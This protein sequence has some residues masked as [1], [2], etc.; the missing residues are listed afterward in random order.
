MAHWTQKLNELEKEY[1]I[2]LLE[3]NSYYELMRKEYTMATTEQK[4]ELVDRILVAYNGFYEAYF[5]IYAI[6]DSIEDFMS[7]KKC[8]IIEAIDSEDFIIKEF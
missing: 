8:S 2:M 5:S 7:A 1:V 6:M 3:N 4:A